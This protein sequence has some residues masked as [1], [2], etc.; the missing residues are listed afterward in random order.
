[1]LFDIP[2]ETL[3]Q[4]ISHDGSEV[5]WPEYKEPNCYRG[6]HMQ[7]VVDLAFRMGLALIP[8]HACPVSAP[9]L[10]A[11]PRDLWDD[12][13]CDERLGAYLKKH[14]GILL[15]QASVKE[16]LVGHAVAWDHETQQIY[17][18][19]GRIYDLENP[20]FFIRELWIFKTMK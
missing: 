3:I 8:I 12:E 10:T 1:M 5:W 15:G 7:E 6:V 17:D 4:E 14:N 19:A 20:F 2:V 18:P 13:H 9:T 16:K 11:E